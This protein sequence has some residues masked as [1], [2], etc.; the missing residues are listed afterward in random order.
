MQTNKMWATEH[1]RPSP[2]LGQLSVPW[3]C[4]NF[5]TKEYLGFF[6]KQ[7]LGSPHP[8]LHIFYKTKQFR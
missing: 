2:L 6:Q 3:C 5:A 1:S 4:F 7:S 8:T